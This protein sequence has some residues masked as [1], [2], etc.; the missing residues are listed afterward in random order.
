MT[1]LSVFLYSRHQEPSAGSCWFTFDCSSGNGCD[2]LCL[3]ND[4]KQDL[5]GH[6]NMW[7]IQNESDRSLNYFH[8]KEATEINV[9]CETCNNLQKHGTMEGLITVI[10]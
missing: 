2:N 5:W 9:L 4:K 6:L 10:V 8:N 1:N 3:W 7:Q